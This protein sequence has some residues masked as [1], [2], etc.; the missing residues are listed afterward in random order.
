MH[1]C[2][3][4]YYTSHVG[5]RW[6]PNLWPGEKLGEGE[7]VEGEKGSGLS[8]AHSLAWYRKA[9]RKMCVALYV[10]MCRHK[11]LCECT[12]MFTIVLDIM[13]YVHDIYC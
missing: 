10:C 1:I 13:P 2:C 3:L 11:V 5:V 4:T 6:N 9:G 8:S 7:G 12:C